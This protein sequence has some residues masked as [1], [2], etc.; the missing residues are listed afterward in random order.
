MANVSFNNLKLSA[1]KEIKI[2]EFNNT[3][4]E[5]LQYLPIE[6]KNDLIQITMQ[7]SFMDGYFNE[8][9]L[10]AYFHLNIIY[11]Y[12]NLNITEKQREDEL[13]LYDKIYSSG[14]MAAILKQ[15]PEDE[16]KYLYDVLQEQVDN[17][18]KY[19]NSAAA[20]MQSFIQDLPANAAAAADIVNNWDADKFQSVQ[21]MVQLARQ[22]GM[23]PPIPESVET[24]TPAE[25]NLVNFLEE[26]AKLEKKE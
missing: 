21:D 12:T 15:L 9:L 7:K 11:L 18:L 10:D 20:V 1:N 25:A 13:K 5:V 2:A 19:K 3:K 22:T 26:Q 16:Y 23:N 24:A 17:F 8:I 4:I 6:D 14:L